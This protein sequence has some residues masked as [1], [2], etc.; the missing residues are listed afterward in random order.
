MRPLFFALLLLTLH[1]PSQAE[2]I[3]IHEDEAIR[4]FADPA[5]IK[6]MKFPKMKVLRDFKE[7]T[8]NG[9][10]SARLMYEADCENRRVRL[11]N[12]VYLKKAMGEGEVSG[13]INSNGWQNID[14]REVLTKVYGMLCP[15][16]A[17]PPSN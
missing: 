2:W 5:S 11:A 17:S 10:Y 3:L 14:A 4:Y 1:L 16:T 12:G 15:T 8:L 6:A 9:D 7:V 13:M